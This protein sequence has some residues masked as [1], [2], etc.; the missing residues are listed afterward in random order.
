MVTQTTS[1][2]DPAPAEPSTIGSGGI[3]LRAI[4]HDIEARYIGE[5][6]DRSGGVVADAARLLGL[7]RTTLIEKMRRHAA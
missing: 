4:L 2:I 5:A 7:Q 6:M 3:D 1:V